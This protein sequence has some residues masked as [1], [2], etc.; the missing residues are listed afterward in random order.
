MSTPK[1]LTADQCQSL[2]DCF[3]VNQGTL[4]QKRRGFRNFAMATLMLE[5][6]VRVG[7]LCGLLISDLWY[8]CEPVE[9]L[10]VRKEIAKNNQE[11]QIPISHKLAETLKITYSMFWSNVSA[12]CPSF[13]FYSRWPNVALTTRTVER[14]IL[15]A[16]REAL[17]LEV[18]PHMLRHTFASRMMRKT[19]SRIVQALL[20]H[21]NLQSTQIYMHPNAEDLKKAINS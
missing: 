16:G 20:G 1:T 5:T 19:N 13:A 15:A 18:T 3:T 21:S 14:I 4:K 17:N 7:E 11:R 10:V 2:L 6:G 9:N 12:S 8:S